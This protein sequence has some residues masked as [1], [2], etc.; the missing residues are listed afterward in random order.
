MLQFKSFQFELRLWIKRN[1][2]K[3]QGN[4]IWWCGPKSHFLLD[5]RV[6]MKILP[7]K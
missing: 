4:L 5:A 1:N 7:Y 2:I 6:D 3:K